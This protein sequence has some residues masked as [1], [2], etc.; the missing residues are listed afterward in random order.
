MKRLISLLAFLCAFLPG[1]D[2]VWGQDFVVLEHRITDGAELCTV[3]DPS[4]DIYGLDDNGHPIGLGY[5]YTDVATGTPDIRTQRA[6]AFEVPGV[7]LEGVGTWPHVHE[8]DPSRL[9]IRLDIKERRWVGWENLNPTESIEGFV[10]MTTHNSYQLA[11]NTSPT[12]PSYEL[13]STNFGFQSGWEWWQP[14]SL[15]PFDGAI[16]GEGSS[17]WRFSCGPLYFHQPQSEWCEPGQW[18]YHTTSSVTFLDWSD[19]SYHDRNAWRSGHTERLK[20]RTR[21]YMNYHAGGPPLDGPL[22]SA[23][24]AH[25]WAVEW[26]NR[27]TVDVTIIALD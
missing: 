4:D 17:G 6:L 19:L 23:T 14:A 25:G 18:D 8:G 9:M 26:G 22:L 27:P 13:I 11:R 24:N 15:A 2:L 20:Y 10:L 7:N 5:H 21:Q 16:D 3:V 12:N 1:G